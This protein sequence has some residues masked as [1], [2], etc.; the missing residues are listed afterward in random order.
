MPISV[1]L[2]FFGKIQD[3]DQKSKISTLQQNVPRFTNAP[4]F[5]TFFPTCFEKKVVFT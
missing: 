5:I 3:I 4:F 2:T 1:I